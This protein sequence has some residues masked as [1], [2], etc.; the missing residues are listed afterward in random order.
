MSRDEIK[1]IEFGM[2]DDR[3]SLPNATGGG[4]MK[5]I[6]LD[7]DPGD[8]RKR[9]ATAGDIGHIKI[10]EFDNDPETEKTP[11]PESTK[12]RIGPLKIKEF[13]KEPETRESIGGAPKIKIVEFD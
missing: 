3:P 5:I 4:A 12:N 11:V 9:V 8:S 2:D 6:E 1:I 7:K 10:V 13:G